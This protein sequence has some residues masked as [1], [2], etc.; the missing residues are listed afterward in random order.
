MPRTLLTGATGTLGRALAPKLHE[1]GHD[2]VAASRSPPPDDP[3]RAPSVDDL[4]WVE[5]DLAA[6]AGVEDAVGDVDVV[7]HAATAPQG[8]AEAV[9]VRGTQHCCRA[10]ADA[11]VSNL[12]YPSIVGID[13]IP[14]S[15]YEHKLAAERIVETSPV[16]ETIVRI[17]QFH[18][19][20]AELLD[21]IARLPVWPVP[22][23]VPLQPIAVREA[24][25]AVLDLADPD[26]AG[27]VEPVGGPEVHTAGELARTYREAGGRRR[28]IVRVPLPGKTAA[29]FR[30]GA[31]CCPEHA[32]GSRTWE[33][34]L[35]E[36]HP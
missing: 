31:A 3:D 35:R 17:T 24:A 20:V 29:G 28:P 5:L 6:G 34:W 8:D 11:G 4:E 27:R 16:P 33:A 36:R 10:A 23:G 9:D 14:Y 2:V 7:V 21:S 12:V 25:G 26:P 18:E 30:S 22:R 15:Y 13:E 19:F 32:V 1:A